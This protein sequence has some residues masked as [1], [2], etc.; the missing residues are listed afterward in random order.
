MN[1]T[2]DE[3]N[4]EDK[5]KPIEN[6]ESQPPASADESDPWD[7]FDLEDNLEAPPSHL[8]PPKPGPAAPTS[9][10]TD[11]PGKRPQVPTN[12]M[13]VMFLQAILETSRA[14]ISGPANA[15]LEWTFISQDLEINSRLAKCKDQNDG[16]LHEKRS[17]RTAA[18]NLTWENVNPLEY[19]SIGVSFFIVKTL[20]STADVVQAQQ[21]YSKQHYIHSGDAKAPVAAQMISMIC[22]RLRESKTSLS[23][24]DRT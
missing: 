18:F 13:V 12:V 17:K 9:G 23:E 10:H 15:Y 6:E 1:S 24:Y 2:K 21:M 16:S 5:E 3:K 14:A 7:D 11:S 22:E 19:V 4:A 20:R 8:E